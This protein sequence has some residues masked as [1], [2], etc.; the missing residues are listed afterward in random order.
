M[1]LSAPSPWCKLCGDFNP[2]H[3]SSTLA[4]LFGFSGKIAHGNH[5][6]AKLL[7]I[8]DASSSGSSV[9][10]RKGWWIE[11]QFQ[12]PM[13][14]PIK[15]AARIQEVDAEG[16]QQWRCARDD[17]DGKVYVSGSIGPL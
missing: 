8:L 4:Q 11:M 17:R 5:V 13:V 1:P 2:V 16:E 15:L 12:R 14:L 6:V 10:K 3:V 7:Q 9:G